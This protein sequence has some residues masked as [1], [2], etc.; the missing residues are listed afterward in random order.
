[1]GLQVAAVVAESCLPWNKAISQSPHHPAP[2][3]PASLFHLSR[4][5]TIHPFV[6]PAQTAAAQTQQTKL[7]QLGPSLY[8]LPPK[9]AVPEAGGPPKGEPA[10]EGTFQSHGFALKFT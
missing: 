10:L 3:P 1:M 4:P 7:H 2:P 5:Q 9:L 6:S 8:R